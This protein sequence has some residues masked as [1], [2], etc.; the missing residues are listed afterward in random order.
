MIAR[1]NQFNTWLKNKFGERTLKICIDGGFSCPNRDGTKGCGGCTFCGER[2][3]G[4]NTNRIDIPQQVKNHLS[5]YKADRAGKFIA[6]FQNFSNTY[7]SVETLKERYDSALIDDRIV[8]LAVA[9]RPDCI[10][11]EVAKL[12]REYSQK[13]YVYVELG[14]QTANEGVGQKFNRG[15]SNKEFVKAVKLLNNYGID[16]VTHI[17]VGLPFEEEKDIEKT[18]DFVNSL[19][20]MGVKIHST[21][22][23][24]NTILE[25]LYKEGKYVP[26]T[27]EYYVENVC[28][29]ISHLRPDIV[30]CRITGDAPKDILVEPKWNV[31][32]KIVLNAINRAL[33]EKNIF[34]GKNYKT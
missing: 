25:K 26:I 29:I 21:Y 4:E 1:Y 12:L 14:L 18:V 9:T 22:I 31:R 6:Y 15:Y 28:K 7:A 27:L 34:Q 10:N 24:K 17:M 8:A 30:V 23:I 33:E 20:I 2:G 32:K 3:S 16:I 19:K 11:E 13:Y 5:G